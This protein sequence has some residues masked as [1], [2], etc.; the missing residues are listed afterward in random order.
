MTD[1]PER[2][3]SMRRFT[4]TGA[5]TSLASEVLSVLAT[6]RHSPDA[7]AH[8]FMVTRL[9]AAVLDRDPEARTTVL[10]EMRE[11]RIPD[12]RIAEEIIPEVARRLGAAWCEDSMSFADV[13]IGSA[14]L[15]AMVR[16]LSPDD[17]ES[18]SAPA[19]RI[20]VIVP[21]DEHH[22]L[23]AMILTGRLRR[24][25]A[26][27]R[28]FLARPDGEVLRALAMDDYDAI[29]VS[30]SD[31]EKLVK[32]AGFVRKIRQALLR[33]TPIIVGGS[34]VARVR[35][36]EGEIGADHITSDIEGAL[37]ACGLK[38][39]RDGARRRQTTERLRSPNS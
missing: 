34:L 33:K 39:S 26:S 17:P 31:G 12:A 14:R 15:Q 3:A 4:D 1:G 19:A 23:G 35:M 24:M 6:R 22:T 16:D 29:F 32:L 21:E 5:V 7:T 28:L 37:T 10:A 11:A 30:A 8:E 25:E 38:T 27:V 2:S 20:A 9:E 13:T 36:N 18:D